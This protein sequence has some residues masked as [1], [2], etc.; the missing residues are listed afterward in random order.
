M[1][2]FITCIVTG[3]LLMVS[4]SSEVYKYS[5]CAVQVLLYLYLCIV[6]LVLVYWFT[7]FLLMIS[8]ARA[9][10]LRVWRSEVYLRGGYEYLAPANCCV[11]FD[12]LILFLSKHD[13]KIDP[14]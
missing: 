1:V 13:S 9:S 2:S 14:P 5:T 10:K 8:A 6:F 4:F 7:F 3:L 11:W 12:V